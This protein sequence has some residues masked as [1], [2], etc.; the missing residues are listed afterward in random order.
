M[1]WPMNV[2]CPNCNQKL[3]LPDS[4]AGARLACEYCGEMLQVPCPAAVP[5]VDEELDEECI[6]S[7]LHEV[8]RQS[9]SLHDT[10]DHMEPLWY[11]VDS[12]GMDEH[13]PLTEEQI[14]RAARK[15]RIMRDTLLRQA[16]SKQKVRAGQQLPNLFSHKD[17][18]DDLDDL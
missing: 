7:G 16:E 1:G 8:V 2:L 9:H 14:S 17:D 15:G 18:L 11:I 10:L 13:G 6:A 3:N 12:D 4:A 5:L